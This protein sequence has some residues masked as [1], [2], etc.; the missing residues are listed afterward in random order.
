MTT[1][2]NSQGRCIKTPA[3]ANG[4]SDEKHMRNRI[5]ERHETV[6]KRFKHW[7]CLS[8]RFRSEDLCEFSVACF[9]AVTVMTQLAIECG[10]PLFAAGDDCR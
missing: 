9:R 7:G 1:M 6:N 3:G 8:Q 4:P 10:E 2:A 5:R